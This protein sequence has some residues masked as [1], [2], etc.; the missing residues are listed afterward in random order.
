MINLQIP[1]MANRRS[2]KP[3]GGSG[4]TPSTGT[5]AAGQ[6]TLLSP[7][8]SIRL[9]CWNVR[10]L[11]NPTRQNSRLR[12]VLRTMAEKRLD[13]LALSEVR[14][15]GHGVSQINSFT[16]VHS[17]A[18]ADDPH[19]RRRGVAVVMSERASSAWHFAGSVMEPVSERIIRIRLKS[20]TGFLSL[21]A[22]Y[23]PTNEPASEEESEAFYESLQECV[24]RVPRRDMLLI[25]GDFNARVGNDA[26]TWRGTIGRLVQESRMR[27]VFACWTLAL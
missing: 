7:K 18:A 5:G 26:R 23:A 10:S 8:H 25:L 19:P 17:G 12:A 20:H 9:G 21:I 27:M 1:P 11:G 15:A 3:Q 13:V 22:V 2:R 4:D 6:H 14:W 16:I 24:R